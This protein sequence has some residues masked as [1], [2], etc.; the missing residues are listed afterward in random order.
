MNSNRKSGVCVDIIYTYL[1]VL[2]FA[3]GGGGGGGGV[4]CS[5]WGGAGGGVRGGM[6]VSSSAELNGVEEAE[7]GT[8]FSGAQGGGVG[9]EWGSLLQRS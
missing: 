8:C 6:G 7:G 9:G 5:G 4:G 1:C 3:G 2:V